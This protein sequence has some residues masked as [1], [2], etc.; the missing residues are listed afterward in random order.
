MAERISKVRPIDANL[1]PKDDDPRIDKNNSE[2]LAKTRG[3]GRNTESFDPQSTLVRPEMRILVGKKEKVFSG[4]LKHDDVLVIP[5][6]FCSESDWSIYY[7]LIEE[8]RDSQATKDEKSSSSWIAWHE[9]SHLITKNPEVSAAYME[10]QNKISD[11]FEIPQKSVGTR[12]N[13]YR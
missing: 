11:F 4:K 8:M 10:I 9:G 3:A 7:R 13:W 12:F 5:E 1:P 2:K 6:F